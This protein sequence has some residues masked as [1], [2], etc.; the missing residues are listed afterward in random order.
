MGD[1]DGGNDLRAGEGTGRGWG[2]G[3]G[4]WSGGWGMAGRPSRPDPPTVPICNQVTGCV[5]SLGSIRKS[6]L[7]LLGESLGT[8]MRTSVWCV[9]GRDFVFLS[10]F[11]SRHCSVVLFSWQGPFFLLL[12]RSCHKKH[13]VGRLFVK[14]E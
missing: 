5:V 11:R 6:I 3:M 4:D 1:G 9:P 8:Q 7:S 13:L 14:T 10:L 12:E 2:M